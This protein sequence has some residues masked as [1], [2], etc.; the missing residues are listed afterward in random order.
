MLLNTNFMSIKFDAS[1]SF[2]QLFNLISVGSNGGFT[3]QYEFAPKGEHML[4]K[5]LIS[6]RNIGNQLFFS[7]FIVQKFSFDQGKKKKYR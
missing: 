4:I 5:A 7:F 2:L 1:R 3:L 6:P